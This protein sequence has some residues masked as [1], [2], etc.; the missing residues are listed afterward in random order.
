MDGAE[1]G[2]ADAAAAPLLSVTAPPQACAACKHQ[3]KRCGPSCLL[4]PFF[5]P[6]K[7]R[8]FQWVH[9]VFGVSNV[10]KRLRQL[11]GEDRARAAGAMVWEA[12]CWIEEDPVEGARGRWLRAQREAECLRRQAQQCMLCSGRGMAAANAEMMV[13]NRPPPSYE[14]GRLPMAMADLHNYPQYAQL[15]GGH[16]NVGMVPLPLPRVPPESTFDGF[17][18]Q[19]QQYNPF[20]GGRLT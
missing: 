13:V 15:Q 1:D 5:P 3:R 2:C 11:V 6:E 17:G 4:A 16:A 19:L 9:R 12:R 8:E 14:H 20:H 7:A 18:D 10:A